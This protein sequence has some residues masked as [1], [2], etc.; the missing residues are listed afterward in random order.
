MQRSNWNTFSYGG[1]GGEVLE[2]VGD[3]L[4]S[5]HGTNQLNI[6]QTELSVCHK[7]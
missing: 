3:K 4:Y 2:I 7:L 6:N 1:R 5:Q